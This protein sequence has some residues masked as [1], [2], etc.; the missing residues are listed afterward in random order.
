MP[1]HLVLGTEH[2]AL[3]LLGKYSTNRA[4]ALRDLAILDPV[5]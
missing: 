5:R 2:R 3:G 4:V 1:C